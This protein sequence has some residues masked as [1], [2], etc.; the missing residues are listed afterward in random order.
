MN[1]PMPCLWLVRLR[2]SS[3]KSTSSFHYRARF[4]IFFTCVGISSRKLSFSRNVIDIFS[5]I[6]MQ[7]DTPNKLKV[8]KTAQTYEKVRKSKALHKHIT[9]DVSIIHVCFSTF[10]QQKSISVFQCQTD[11]FSFF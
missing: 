4:Y 8:T 11:T 5:M 10:F 9:N 3:V 7:K 2:L 1:Q 6:E